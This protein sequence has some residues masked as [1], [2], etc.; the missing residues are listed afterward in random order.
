MAAKMSVNKPEIYGTC[1][2]LKTEG[3]NYQNCKQN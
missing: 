2:K 1:I 3:A